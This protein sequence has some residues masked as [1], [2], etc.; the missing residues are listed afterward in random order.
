M[1]HARFDWQDD[2]IGNA[3]FGLLQMFHTPQFSLL[4]VFAIGRGLLPA[5]LSCFFA[6]GPRPAVEHQVGRFLCLFEE[7]F[8]RHA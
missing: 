8:A 2:A 4:A 3:R 5:G 6:W 1:L 7:R